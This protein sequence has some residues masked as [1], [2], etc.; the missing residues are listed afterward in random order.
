MEVYFFYS[1][2][3]VEKVAIVYYL[4]IN[5]NTNNNFYLETKLIYLL[6]MLIA[7]SFSH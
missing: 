7:V 5:Q 4:K 1:F 2:L 3:C 6:V